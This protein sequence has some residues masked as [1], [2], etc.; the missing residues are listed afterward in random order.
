[1]KTLVIFIALQVAI[2]FATSVR[3]PVDIRAVHG[4][5]T[6]ESREKRSNTHIRGAFHSEDG[7]GIR[8]ETSEKSLVVQWTGRVS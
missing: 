6:L 8:F 5:L 2:S 1:M 4:T 7:D 3:R